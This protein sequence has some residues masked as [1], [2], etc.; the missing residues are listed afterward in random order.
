M[1][2]LYRRSRAFRVFCWALLLLPLWQIL[3]FLSDN[4]LRNYSQTGD[5]ILLTAWILF[6]AGAWWYGED[7]DRRHAVQHEDEYAHDGQ[8]YA[9]DGQPAPDRNGEPRSPTT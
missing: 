5:A 3:E 9:H 7:R 8:D 2:R 1:R 4:D 6:A